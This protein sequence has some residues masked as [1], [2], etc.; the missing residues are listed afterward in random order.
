MLSPGIASPQHKSSS[1]VPRE[2]MTKTR[3]NHGFSSPTR[4]SAEVI[5]ISSDSDESDDDFEQLMS[6][7]ITVGAGEAA[8]GSVAFPKT[9]SKVGKA[10][11]VK[12]EDLENGFR[13]QVPSRTPTGLFPH[14]Q[15]AGMFVESGIG[16]RPKE[17][18]AKIA[19]LQAEEPPENRLT[20]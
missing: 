14:K 4:S 2:L 20:L 6:R 8:M 3:Y 7:R 13:S 16:M 11:V 9:A 12:S 19:G 10:P 18:N 5:A 1:S 15:I 17:K